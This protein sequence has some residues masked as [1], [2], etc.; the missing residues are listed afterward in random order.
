[1]AAKKTEKAVATKSESA[2]GQVMDFGDFQGSGFENQTA[3]D[4]T[5]PFLGL[6]QALSPQIKPD[7]VKGA[8]QGMLINTVSEQLFSGDEGVLF[9]PSTTEHCY[10]E[11]VP[12]KKGGGFV[13]RHELGSDVVVKALDK[14]SFNEL[15]TDAGND[16]IETF[17][18]YG[19][20]CPEDALPQPIVIAITSTKIGVYKKWM[21]KLRSYVHVLD[22]GVT[23]QIPPL[24]SHLT[25]I[26]S[27]TQVNSAGQ[28]SYNIVFTPAVDGDV[29]ESLIGPADPRFQ[30]A[31]AFGKMQ[32]GGE[33]KVDFSKSQ[34]GGDEKSGPPSADDL[35]SETP[36]F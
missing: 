35:N 11:W 8:Q 6:L 13:G 19:V 3:A 24:F 17:Y 25:R 5:V 30:A 2:V 31:F 16:L 12:I 28:E 15:E 33:A 21:G 26:T 18:V 27:K 10:V 1:M 36:V 34:G 7:G 22:D 14:F 4:T 9:V 29:R 32:A 23:T 20:L